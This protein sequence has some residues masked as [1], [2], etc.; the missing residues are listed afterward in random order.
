M[1]YIYTGDQVR[2]FPTLKLTLSPQDTFEA[3]ADFLAADCAP[4]VTKPTPTTVG[5]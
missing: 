5:A 3:P 4:V 1:K 2:E